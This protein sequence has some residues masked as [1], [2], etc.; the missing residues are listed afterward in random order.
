ML[1]PIKNSKTDSKR[2][3][4]IVIM[5]PFVKIDEHSVLEALNVVCVPA[6]YIF[7]SGCLYMY[8]DLTAP[9]KSSAAF[10]LVIF[11]REDV[12]S[13]VVLHLEVQ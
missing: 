4:K 9:R 10:S 13:V 6:K 11:S 7:Y 5:Y 2:V 8:R 12:Y 1:V 3:H